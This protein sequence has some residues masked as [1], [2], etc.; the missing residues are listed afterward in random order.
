VKPEVIVGEREGDITD[1]FIV[2]RTFEKK[3]GRTCFLLVCKICS[4]S[5]KIHYF[6]EI[7]KESDGKENE[8]P[9]CIILS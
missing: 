5:K 1:N 3:L 6:C 8:P 9:T 4:I 7:K 2:R